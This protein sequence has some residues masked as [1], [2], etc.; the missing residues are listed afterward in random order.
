MV[1]GLHFIGMRWYNL[2]LERR[3]VAVVS[4]IISDIGGFVDRAIREGYSH[5]RGVGEPLP[6]DVELTHGGGWV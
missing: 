3:F 5:K 4:R 6:I 1:V 2:G